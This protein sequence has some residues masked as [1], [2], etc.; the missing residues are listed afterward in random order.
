[1]H[2]ALL[3][4]KTVQHAPENQGRLTASVLEKKAEVPCGRMKVRSCTSASCSLT[5]MTL[6]DGQGMACAL[7]ACSS[8]GH[9]GQDNPTS[10]CKILALRL[11]GYD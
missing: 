5:V 2:T 11:G 6:G 1:M 8:C 10:L 9:E 7:L 4:Q 3:L